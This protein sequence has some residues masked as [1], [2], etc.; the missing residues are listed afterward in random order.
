MPP[1]TAE[2]RGLVNLMARRLCNEDAVHSQLL[3]QDLE[4]PAVRKKR[5]VL[6]PTKPISGAVT[7]R[8]RGDEAKAQDLDSE[9]TCVHLIMVLVLTCEGLTAVT[10]AGCTSE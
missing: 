9:V 6:Q 7:R 10:Y 3:I 4:K 5:C 1:Q 2:H 8:D